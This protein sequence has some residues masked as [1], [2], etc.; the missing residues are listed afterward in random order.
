MTTDEIRDAVRGI[1]GELKVACEGID[2]VAA[3][4]EL[5][6]IAATEKVARGHYEELINMTNGLSREMWSAFAT[7]RKV[8]GGFDNLPDVQ[9]RLQELKK[10]TPPTATVG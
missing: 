2:A 1:L 8:M 10:Q 6:Q 4:A 7:L 3:A 5:E 9:A